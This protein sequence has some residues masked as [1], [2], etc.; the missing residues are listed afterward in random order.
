MMSCNRCAL[1]KAGWSGVKQYGTSLTCKILSFWP[2]TQPRWTNGGVWAP[3]LKSIGGAHPYTSTSSSSPLEI[4]LSGVWCSSTVSLYRTCKIHYNIIIMYLYMYILIDTLY[5][6]NFTHHGQ[7]T[8]F[9][10][11]GQ[12]LKSLTHDGMA[13]VCTQSSTK[14]IIFLTEALQS[15]VG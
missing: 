8:I 4:S 3:E 10:S 6:H 9:A 11:K 12:R 15:P 1:N 7:F 5:K 14:L 13:C 2:L